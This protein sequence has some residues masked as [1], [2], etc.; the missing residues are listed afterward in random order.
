MRLDDGLTLVGC[1]VGKGLDQVGPRLLDGLR[2]ERRWLFLD[3]IGKLI[4]A[5]LELVDLDGKVADA[6]AACAFVERAALE[7]C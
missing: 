7:R 3:E 5:V 1:A 4:A 6:V 2:V